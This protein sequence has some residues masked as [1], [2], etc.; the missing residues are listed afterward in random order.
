[1]PSRLV[2]VHF[3]LFKNAGT[4]VE[5][6]LQTA[7]GDGWVSY[8]GPTAAQR[9]SQSDIESHL[10][11]HPE[12]SCIS[13]HQVRPPLESTDEFR[14]LP[15]VF[16]RDPIDRLRSAYEFERNQGPVSPSA[17]AAAEGSLAEWIDFHNGRGSSQ[18]A[19]F[20]TMALTALRNDENGAPLARLPLADH[21]TSAKAFLGPLGAIGVV[22]E[23]DQSMDALQ[24]WLQTEI[25]DFSW[26]SEF[27]NK[28]ASSTTNLEARLDAVAA[29]LGDERYQ[30][31]VEANQADRDILAW[32]ASRK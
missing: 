23:F 7:F 20:Q 30:A 5:A 27:L 32:V 15:V 26:T 11:E 12:V 31:L 14:F 10:H 9:L 24:R 3:H 6:S 21:V 19:N 18:C 2:V 8:D 13:S 1:M 29:E 28:G 22:E 4:S 16:L 25:P 17:R